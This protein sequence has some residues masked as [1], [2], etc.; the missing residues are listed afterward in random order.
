ML[1]EK[2]CQSLIDVNREGR[3]PA[4]E[5]CG[6]LATGLVPKIASSR[7]QVN[8]QVGLQV[9]LQVGFQVSLLQLSTPTADGNEVRHRKF[10]IPKSKS[11]IGTMNRSSNTYLLRK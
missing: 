11:E 10:F 8:L 7:A 6:P 1:M 4:Q 2:Q 5:R 3:A 9:R